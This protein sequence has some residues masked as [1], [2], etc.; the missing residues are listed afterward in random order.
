MY[1]DG[2]IKMPDG[3]ILTPRQPYDATMIYKK[4]DKVRENAKAIYNGAEAQIVK[5][6]VK[7]STVADSKAMRVQN[8][9]SQPQSRKSTGTM[10]RIMK[11]PE[12]GIFPEEGASHVN[13]AGSSV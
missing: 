12:S 2:T 7:D 3:Q 8:P 9:V 6:D 5:V 4:N 13:K 1:A 10:S 11:I